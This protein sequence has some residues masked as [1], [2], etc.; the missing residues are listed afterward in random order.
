VGY[1]PWGWASYHYGR[2]SFVVNI[3]WFWVPPVTREVY[4]SPGYVGWVRTND[5]V[6]W[7]PLAPGEIYYG[8]DHYGRHSVNITNV[9]IDQ[10]NIT[11]V[12]KNA[13]INNGAT[14]VKRHT[15]NTGS[16]TIVNVNRKIKEKIF[17]KN[18]FSVGSPVF[19]RK[20]DSYFTSDKSIPQ[21]KLPPKHIGNI[22]VKELKETRRP[23]KEQKKSFLSSGAKSKTLPVKNIATSR[24]SRKEKP[25]MQQVRP[26]EKKK[27][28][29]PE[30]RSEPRGERKQVAPLKRMKPAISEAGPKKKDKKYSVEIDNSPKKD[31]K[32]GGKKT[33]NDKHTILK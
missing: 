13:Y 27:H 20:G 18:N 29:A 25:M 17:V 22:K 9:N 12:Y 14:V 1:E 6:A 33:L 7:V 32:K 24:T 3:G 2:W 23:I 4:W 31:N 28:V 19:K 30:G 16:P 10:V 5:Y 26:E 8:R 11:N 21:V 15:F